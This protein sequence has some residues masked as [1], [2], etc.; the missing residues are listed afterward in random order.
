M[1]DDSFS[2]LLNLENIVEDR[3]QMKKLILLT[4][5]KKL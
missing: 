5:L 1:E 4:N 2:A 3:R